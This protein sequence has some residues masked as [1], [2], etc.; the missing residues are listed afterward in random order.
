MQSFKLSQC[1]LMQNNIEE[2]TN[3]PIEINIVAN[4][5]LVYFFIFFIGKSKVSMAP[6][7]MKSS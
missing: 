6:F 1:L 5:A 2:K 3:E 4:K 7:L